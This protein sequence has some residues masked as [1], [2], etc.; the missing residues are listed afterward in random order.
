MEREI[1]FRAKM[2]DSMAEYINY[3]GDRWVRGFY[4]KKLIDE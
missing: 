3:N 1:K 2:T 4:Y